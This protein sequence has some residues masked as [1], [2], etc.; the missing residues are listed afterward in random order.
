MRFR[1]RSRRSASGCASSY[2]R[3]ANARL[4]WSGPP[5]HRM[6][7]LQLTVGYAQGVVAGLSA[8]LDLIESEIGRR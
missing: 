5:K 3:R 2:A 1:I 4:R 6:S 7:G 8:A